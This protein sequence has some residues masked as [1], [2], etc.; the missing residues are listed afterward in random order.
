MKYKKI[1]N[2]PRLNVQFL[3]SDTDEVIF[4]VKNRTWMN[5]GELLSED[6]VNQVISQNI[7]GEIPENLM[8][9]IVGEYELSE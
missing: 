6:I 2:N 1:D 9:L 7:K 5:V 3:D 4:E 8:V